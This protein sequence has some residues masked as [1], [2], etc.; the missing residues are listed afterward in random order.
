MG[1]LAYSKREISMKKT[2]LCRIAKDRCKGCMLCVD[3]CPTK[4]L[5]VSS[6]F[7]ILGYHYVEAVDDACIGCRRCATICPDACI[8]L[9]IEESPSCE[10]DREK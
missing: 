6:H 1:F 3:V 7:N 9:Y 10:K 8:E 4:T 2:I 5:R